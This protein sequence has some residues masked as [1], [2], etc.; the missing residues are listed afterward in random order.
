M[1]L[2]A[3]ERQHSLAA[4]ANNYHTAISVMDGKSRCFEIYG[5]DILLD[6]NCHPW[7]LEVNCMPSLTCD[8]PFDTSLKFSVIKGT[9]KIIELYPGFK[10]AVLARQKAITQKRISGMHV[11]TG[12]SPTLCFPI[13][14]ISDI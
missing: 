1:P 4:A 12:T 6:S 2:T 7:L 8:S 9:L 11:P 14:M 5:F 13:K 10:K 3:Q